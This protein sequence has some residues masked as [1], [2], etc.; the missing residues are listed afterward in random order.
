MSE[1][2]GQEQ[3]QKRFLERVRDAAS[4]LLLMKPWRYDRELDANGWKTFHAVDADVVKLYGTPVNLARRRGGRPGYAEVFADDPEDGSYAIAERLADHI[5]FALPPAD[6]PLLVIPPIDGEVRAMLEV[7]AVRLG[8]EPEGP[9]LDEEALAA[10]TARLE[11]AIGAKAPPDVLSDV[12]HNVARL[13]ALRGEGPESEYRRL[14]EILALDRIVPT[15]S[16]DKA[17]GCFPKPFIATLKETRSM[18]DI[19]QHARLSADWLKRIA[20]PDTPDRRVSTHRHSRFVHD[21]DAMARLEIWNSRLHEH[22]IRIVY[23]TGAVHLIGAA[24]SHVGEDDQDFFTKYIRHPRYYLASPDVVVSSRGSEQ[25]SGEEEDDG[26]EVGRSQIQGWIET[27]IVDCRIDSSDLDV[28][29]YRFRL[30]P[31]SEEVARNAFQANS[32]LDQ[33]VMDKWRRYLSTL[34]SSYVPPE[35]V[36][37]RIQDDLV[38]AA[39]R[40]AYR[41][42][43]SVRRNLEQQ[44]EEEKDGAWEACFQ[45]AASAGFF[46]QSAAIDGNLPPRLVPVLVLGRWPKTEEFVRSLTSWN[47]E[48]NVNSREYEDGVQRVKVETQDEFSYAFYLV[49]AALSAAR[50]NWKTGAILSTRA[51]EK[52]ARHPSVHDPE[53]V[54]HG[55]EASY[56]AAYCLRHVARNF[57]DLD[58]AERYIDRAILLH[59]RETG[60]NPDLKAL[61]ERFDAEKLALEMTRMCFHRY[62]AGAGS[63]QPSGGS[64]APAGQDWLGIRTRCQELRSRLDG[65]GELAGMPDQVRW[66]QSWIDGNICTA[67]FMADDIEGEPFMEAGERLHEFLKD[68][69]DFQSFHLRSLET[70]WMAA[71]GFLEEARKRLESDFDEEQ[72]SR[73]T[74]LIYD[75]SRYEDL[76]SRIMEICSQCRSDTHQAT[77]GTTR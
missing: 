17:E 1:C 19:L 42:W 46:V 65:A 25:R 63:L 3:A 62:Q 70:L 9:H 11:D 22:R 6:A 7:L 53:A 74:V 4:Q 71:G 76:K 49:H 15:H 52:K 67:S 38:L 27:F 77:P 16:V 72:V 18:S 40:E 20:P 64:Q 47:R 28:R 73:N 48:A 50:G 60:L 33:E 8:S 75:R 29:D 58:E 59:Q 54:G 23:I 39:K 37:E 26:D 31:R 2:I 45:S 41:N 66:L 30:D 44:I 36:Q 10:F 56:L 57:P 24:L 32:Q 61:P 68:N 34:S 51:V 69:Q 35:I 13:V 14:N 21:S 12:L 55:R 5:F 43:R